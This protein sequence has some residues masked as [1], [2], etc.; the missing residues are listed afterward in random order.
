MCEIKVTSHTI[1]FV[2]NIS[3]YFFL[4]GS[5]I[6]TS[7]SGTVNQLLESHQA[8]GEALIPGANAGAVLSENSRH[9]G[10]TW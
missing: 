1:F 2:T 4:S 9:R 10:T 3:A 6:Q 7:E 8:S 5:L